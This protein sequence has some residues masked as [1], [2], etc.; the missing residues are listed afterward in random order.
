M[1]GGIAQRGIA[2]MAAL[3]LLGCDGFSGGVD[4]P[5]GNPNV[6]VN[7][8]QETNVNDQPVGAEATFEDSSGPDCADPAGEECPVDYE[9][10]SNLG[11]LAHGP[12]ACENTGTE[13][14]PS[15]ESFDVSLPAIVAPGQ[16]ITVSVDWNRCNDCNPG[17]V[18]YSSFVGDWDL[19][20]PLKTRGGYFTTCSETA[21]DSVAFTAPRQEG[22]YRIRWIVCMAFDSIRN[23]C[24]DHWIGGGEDPGVC[25]YVEAS[26]SVCR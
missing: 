22:T 11:L 8:I 3:A 5:I 21:T 1:F 16:S 9:A 6:N 14:G 20:S 19:D 13:P 23:F 24:G 26:F 17:A 7:V 15:I 2:L 10:D 4:V 25:P 12:G 18:I